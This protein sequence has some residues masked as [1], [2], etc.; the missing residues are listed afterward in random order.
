MTFQLL[1]LNVMGSKKLFPEVWADDDQMSGL[2]SMIKAREVNPNDYDR[3]IEFW[4][5]MIAKSCDSE[6][7]SVFTIDIL[8]RRFRRGDQ[9]PGSLNVI[10]QHMLDTGEIITV[11]DYK[12]RNQNWLQRR[13]RSFMGSLWGATSDNQTE[14]VHLL[15][16]QKHADNMLEFFR[17]EYAVDDDMLPEIVDSAEFF[18]ECKNLVANKK[19]YDIAL[20]E[21]VNRG[22]VTIGSSKIGE[23]ILKFRDNS[24]RGT[25]K[26][27][28]SDAS[29]HDMRRAMSKLEHEIKR[30]ELKAKKAE[31]DARLYIRQ[32]DKNHAAHYLR[33]KKRALKE[34]EAKDNQYQR[35]LEMIQQLGRTRQNKQILDAYKAGA[36]AFK[37]TLQR[38]GISPEE[39]DE[40]MDNIG[41]AMATAEEIQD[42]IAAGVPTW[43]TDELNKDLELELNSILAG[44]SS[45]IDIMIKSLPDISIEEPSAAGSVETPSATADDS[46][47]ARL[48]RLRETA[49]S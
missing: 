28:E 6:K 40:T 38:Q 5:D 11:D 48:K 9:L 26:W 49:L 16:V 45:D 33:Q 7:N 23:E 24:V 27:T 29:V 3:K 20:A 18:D 44:D 37:A 39:I 31:Q 30:L 2:M 36:D 34:V 13:Y 4:S 42:A 21:L 1:Y 14:Y 8:K 41:D 10:I 35:L 12:A 46:I 25:I 43:T 22:E 17:S 32:G 47:A 15:T 19:T